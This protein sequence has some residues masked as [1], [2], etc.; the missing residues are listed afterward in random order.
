MLST[1]ATFNELPE[2]YILRGRLWA[3]GIP[4]WITHEYQIANDWFR[5]TARHGAWVQV[6]TV[7]EANALEIVRAA[8]A[9][10]FK[11]QLSGQFGEL[12]DLHCPNCGSTDFWKRRPIVTA[13]FAMT[14]GL[15][16][17]ITPLVR[18]IYFCNACRCRFQ[19][20][21]GLIGKAG[22]RSQFDLDIAEANVSDIPE[23]MEVRCAVVE[24]RLR[25]DPNA[26]S[27]RYRAL[28]ETGG[29][30]WVCRIGGFLR[31]FSLA[32][33]EA[34]RLH[35]VFVQPYFKRDGIG[36]HLHNAAVDWLFAQSPAELGLTTEAGTA[37]EK[38]FRKAGWRL[39]DYGENED[40][41]FELEPA[42][43]RARR[44]K[45]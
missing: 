12:E 20:T 37:A 45:F 21:Y 10:A 36:R 2:A 41:I 30:G 38:F 43:W 34:K 18:W 16:L 19:S 9:G 25:I 17:G 5:A 29:K 13:S 6:P 1:V 33:P 22:A 23:M 42:I 28:L 4:S 7:D 11:A 31:G 27:T 24:N 44:A 3:E 39:L 15:L 40:L 35:G 26:E 8:R 14:L 32:D